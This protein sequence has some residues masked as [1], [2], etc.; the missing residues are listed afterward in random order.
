MSRRAPWLIAALIFTA[1]PALADQPD[2]PPSAAPASAAPASTAAPASKATPRKR[3]G[4]RKGS[5][6][7]AKAAR[8]REFKRRAAQEKR[9]PVRRPPENK[10]R[11]VPTLGN[12]P[13]PD[14]EILEFSIKMFGAEAAKAKFEVERGGTY[15]DRP[16][17]TFRANLVGSDF[18]NK[19][20]PLNDSLTLRVDEGSF[21][22]V[23]SDFHIE[24]NG[25]VIDYHTDFFQKRFQVLST[26]TR[27]GKKQVRS[28]RSRG[29][30]YDALS[31]MYAARRIDLKPG[32]AFDY[33]VWDGRRERLISV[34]VKGKERVWTP[35]GWFDAMKLE[36]TTKITGGFI[37]AKVLDRPAKKGYAWIALDEA[38]TPVKLTTP[39][40][41][42]AAEAVLVRRAVPSKG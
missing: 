7:A 15:G 35:V 24:E 27:K 6:L 8:L 25:K 9:W 20:Y 36:I 18:L 41:L 1:A 42:G 31:S 28:F 14:G 37:A 40:K 32:M 26:K 17:V 38:R 39:T 33:F 30:I 29:V 2:A 19:I 4:I 3:R 22:P 11:P 23:K 34:Q 5:K 10:I 12:V 16:T 21:R 13:F